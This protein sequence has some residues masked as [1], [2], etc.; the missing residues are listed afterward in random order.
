MPVRADD[1]IPKK[2]PWLKRV[3]ADA[4]EIVKDFDRF[5]TNYITP[6]K[7]NY[8]VMLQGTH[9]YERYTL[10]S[11]A[12]QSVVLAPKS[13]L[14][15]GPYVGWRWIFLGY[16]I[17][18][19]HLRDETRKEFDMSLYSSMIGIDL[20]S[21]KNNGGY[22]I[23]S[24]SQDGKNYNKQ[25]SH[26]AFDGIEVAVRGFNLYYIFNHRKFSYPAAFNQTNVQ[27][28]SV[29]SWLMGIGYTHHTTKLDH[30]R[31]R[32]V[33][34]QK[35]NGDVVL[36]STF[37][38]SKLNYTDISASV[39]YAYNY[40]FAPRWLFAASLSLAIGYKYTVG[41]GDR[42]ILNFKFSEFKFSNF[43]LDGVGRFGLVYNRMRWYAGASAILH[44]YNYNKSR[45]SVNSTFGNFNV[46]AGYNFGKRH[47][48]KKK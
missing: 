48:D 38:I 31:L 41:D 12:G 4:Y 16:Q 1:S 19:T 23:R 47:R 39:G 18:L 33:I 34:E 40:V 45:I 6:Q 22:F 36:D 46:Y 25:V 26:M 7:Y 32:S 35:T 21:R 15:L 17:D 24:V 29:G 28:R 13:S 30:D 2:K 14:K 20:F 37:N 9:T 8:T 43:N 27:K 44:T 11:G 3:I 42:G 5:D 10:R